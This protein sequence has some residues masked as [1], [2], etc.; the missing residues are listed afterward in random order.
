ML[1]ILLVILILLAVS[2]GIYLT[3]FLWL[4]LGVVIGIIVVNSRGGR[5]LL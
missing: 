5:T 3:P 2:G 4:L 1:T